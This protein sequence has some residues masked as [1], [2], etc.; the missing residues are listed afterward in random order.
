MLKGEIFSQKGRL[1]TCGVDVDAGAAPYGYVRA[2]LLPDRRAAPPGRGA[3][4]TC[5]APAVEPSGYLEWCS[6]TVAAL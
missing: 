1:W 6:S 5:V 2:H 3:T 4:A